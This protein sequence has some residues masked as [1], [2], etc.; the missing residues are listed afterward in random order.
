MIQT[1]NSVGSGFFVRPDGLLVT[2]AHVIDGAR[3]ITVLTYQCLLSQ[4]GL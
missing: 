4:R 3:Q 1:E 2:N